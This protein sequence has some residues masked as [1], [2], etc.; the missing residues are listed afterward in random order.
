MTVAEFSVVL[1]QH[2]ERLR[3]FVRSR[4]ADTDEADDIVQ[5]VCLRAVGRLETIRDA[6]RVESWLFQI[7][8]NAII[9][10]YRRK[11]PV[12]ELPAD[13]IDE[14]GSGDSGRPDLSACLPR[15]LDGMVEPDREALQLTAIEG[16]KQRE[17][18]ERLGISLS[19]AKS[20]VQRARKRLRELV[21]ACCRPDFDRLGQ[22]IEIHPSPDCRAER[23]CGCGVA[24]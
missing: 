2:Y 7:A 1:E 23:P 24:C 16:M 22:I 3:R 20:R 11:R 13:L 5:D 21:I 9:D 17:L 12:A 18:A 8:R 19:G 6:A 4:V 15:L 10:H 14:S